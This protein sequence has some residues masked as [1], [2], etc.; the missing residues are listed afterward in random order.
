MRIGWIGTGVMGRSMCGHLLAAGYAVTVFNRTK[1]SAQHLIEKNA[2]WAD[3]PAEVAE[4]T[5]VVFSIVGYP[6]DVEE[7]YLGPKGVFAAFRP[8]CTAVDMTTS[9]PSLARRLAEEGQ[10]CGVGVL[11]APVS[12]GDIGARNATLSIM[13]G[14]EP[15]TFKQVRPLLDRLGKTVVLQGPAGSGQHTKLVNQ[16]LITGTMVSL[17]EALLYAKS[18]GLDPRVVLQSVSG[19]AAASWSLQNMYPRIL[20]GNLE[21]G[22]YVEHFIKDMGLALAEAER[23]KLSL[24]GLALAKQLYES[25]LANGG[26]RKGTQALILALEAL[27][28]I[29]PTPPAA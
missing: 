20:D 17:C 8:G 22:F 13:V 7:I 18:A 23:L 1:A 3:S 29:K 21:P 12:G 4:R 25:V 26:A 9:S 27:N 24:P 6:A 28:G 16:I 19:G 2:A 10:A 15:E 11:D 5:D 14:G